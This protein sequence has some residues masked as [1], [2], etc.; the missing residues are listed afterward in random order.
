[1]DGVLD[2]FV[3]STM[4]VYLETI[5]RASQDGTKVLR[6]NNQQMKGV[7]KSLSHMEDLYRAGSLSS[8]AWGQF[9]LI[10]NKFRTKKFAAVRIPIPFSD[11]VNGKHHHEYNG[12]RHLPRGAKVHTQ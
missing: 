7:R 8:E 1:M 2:N 11:K 4:G 9:Q 6:F 3:D 12:G 10:Q 5:L